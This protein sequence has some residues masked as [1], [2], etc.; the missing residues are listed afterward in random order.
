MRT[1]PRLASASLMTLAVGFG[2]VQL[3]AV[4]AGAATVSASRAAASTA[5]CIVTGYTLHAK[6]R[7]VEKHVTTKDVET[8][9]HDTC[10][11]AVYQPNGRYKYTVG[12]V[13]VI[14]LPSGYVVTV[15]RN[16]RL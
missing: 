14:A 9:V 13:G 10:R 4:P 5:P 15:W 11:Q 1:I 12:K 8:I 3:A 16:R 6:E 7:M 2:A